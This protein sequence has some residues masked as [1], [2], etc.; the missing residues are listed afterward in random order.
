MK[1]TLNN[2]Q[3]GKAT[4]VDF[5]MRPQ[6]ASHLWFAFNVLD[7]PQDSRRPDARY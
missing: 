1:L 7:W 6:T 5:Q 4:F 3:A 2:L